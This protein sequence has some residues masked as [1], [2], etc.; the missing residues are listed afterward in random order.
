MSEE[1]GER[2]PDRIA[3]L[4]LDEAVD[5][6]VAQDETR[7]PDEV[8][9]A[10]YH[11]SEDG[12]V[13]PEHVDAELAH[14][15]KVVSTPETR[16]ELAEIALDDARDAAEP[17]A[18][19]DIVQ[20]RLEDFAARLEA[21]EKRLPVLREDLQSLVDTD[22]EAADLYD[23]AV[24]IQQLTAAA[25]ATQQAADELQLDIESFERWLANADVRAREFDEDLDAFETSLDE[26][27][28]AATVVADAAAADAAT[29]TSISDTAEREDVGLAWA[30]ASMNHGVTGLLVADLRAELADLRA[31]ADRED[32][33]TERLADLDARLDALATRWDGLGDRLDDLARPAWEAR[34]GEQL[35]GFET[36]LDGFETPVEWGAVQETLDEYRTNL[37]TA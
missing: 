17:V 1:D 2:R 22:A 24:S 9:R 8:R 7:D 15:S 21:V 11:V 16:V 25:N 35:D 30:D 10:L 32:A 33:T 37:Q 6:V 28:E 36:A 34:F 27:D 4:S 26:L 20:A 12:V 29:E 18:D 14:V 13:T 5:V 3:G 23:L 19:L 31:W